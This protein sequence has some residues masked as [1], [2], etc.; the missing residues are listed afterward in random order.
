MRCAMR[1]LPLASPRSGAD[2]SHLARTQMGRRTPTG[3]R[4][5]PQTAETARSLSR[6]CRRPLKYGNIAERLV[7]ATHQPIAHCS[8]QRA[9]APA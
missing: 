1:M 3:G 4:A 8:T 6:G 9:S 2:P 7:V 5:R